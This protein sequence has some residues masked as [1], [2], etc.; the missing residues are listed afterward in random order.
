MSSMDRKPLPLLALLAIPVLALS[1]PTCAQSPSQWDQA[2]QEMAASAPTGMART[3]DR[4]EQL[5]NNN[6]MSFDAYANFLIANPDFPREER[7]RSLAENALDSEAVDAARLV[8]FF[9]QYPPLSNGAKARFALALNAVNRP[10]ASAVAIE[11]WRGGD[12]SGPSAAYI[13]GLFGSGFTQS[14]HDARMDAL[15]WQGKAD[16]ARRHI[17]KTS[18]V[19]QSLFN[20]RLAYL[21][22]NSPASAGVTVPA[23][24]SGDAGYVFNQVRHYRGT[25]QGST[26]VNILANRQQFAD[27]PFDSEALLIEMLRLAKTGTARQAQQIAAKVDDMFEPGVDIRT[28]SYRIR[29]DYTSLMWLGGTKSLWTLGDA[30]A[31]APLFYRYGAAAQTPQTRSKGFYWAGLAAS[32]AG[33]MAGAN[34][35]WEMAAIHPDRFYGMLALDKLGRTMPSLAKQPSA[36]PTPQQASEF[37]TSRIANAV[38]EVSKRSPWKTGIQ[39]YRTIAQAADTPAEHALVADLAIEIGRRDL[40]VNVAEAA[41]ADGLKEFV[42]F[43]HP[44]LDNPQGTDWTM[45]HAITRQESQFAENA[46]SHAGARGLM[47]LMPGTAREQSGKLGMSYMRA[48]LINDTNYNMKL[49]DAYFARM[50]RYYDGAYP[51]AIAAYNA[52]PGNVNKWLRSNGDPRKGG[53]D[54][55]TWGE[56]IPI[57]ETKNYVQRVIENAVVYEQLY[58]EKTL[59]GSARTVRAFL[60]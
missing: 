14:D 45:V 2:R 3:I 30:A 47:Q 13:E 19:K 44:L 55:V 42:P 37:S 36:V 29:D 34:R 10:E 17:T 54:W 21:D 18:P 1:A 39:F 11:A 46:I 41:G 56:R 53:I 50:L 52:G 22:G 6:R 7:L 4:W 23:G 58:P 40:A 24:A 49:G 48:D 15:L 16:D 60:R 31:A 51:L 35:Y 9:N 27:A 26:A 5:T 20:A 38:R 12:M 8:A 33:D 25:R 28:K 57:F 32:K 43:G 59:Y